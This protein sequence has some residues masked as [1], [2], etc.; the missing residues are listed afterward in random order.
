MGC[1]VRTEQ[2]SRAE[3][4]DIALGM[5]SGACF[6]DRHVRNPDDIQM[7]FPLLLFANDELRA[8]MSEF[9]MPGGK[10]DEN[11]Q[12][13]MIY[14]WMEKAGPRS[15]N[16][17]PMFW[18]AQMLNPTET[19]IVLDMVQELEAK[20]DELGEPSDLGEA[21]RA[22]WQETREENLNLK[23]RWWQRKRGR[24]RKNRSQT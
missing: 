19:Q 20:A 16:G 12:T 11:G 21:Y 15:V 13:G 7:V 18:S 17:M 3:L 2:L 6:T 4:R 14:E 23:R 9:L 8:E 10:P 22:A 1:Q 5:M 24:H